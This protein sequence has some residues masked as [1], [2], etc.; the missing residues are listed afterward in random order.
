MA[1]VDLRIW[2]PAYGHMIRAC[3]DREAALVA[4]ALLRRLDAARHGMVAFWVQAED[5]TVERR[6]TAYLRGL[7]REIESDF[8]MPAPVE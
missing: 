5:P 1:A 7:C 3:S 8:R 4:E 6:L 2:T